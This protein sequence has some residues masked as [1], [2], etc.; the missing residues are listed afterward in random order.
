MPAALTTRHWISWATALSG[1]SA[2]ANRA[3]GCSGVSRVPSSGRMSMR[4]ASIEWASSP[5]S[6]K[7][8]MARPCPGLPV[9]GAS[10]I[11]NSPATRPSAS[12]RTTA[13]PGSSVAPIMA[14]SFP[15]NSRRESVL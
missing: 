10:S 12:A 9:A 1:S 15:L 3:E 6:A 4:R 11:R 5:F 14:S 13:V 8:P 2:A 7:T